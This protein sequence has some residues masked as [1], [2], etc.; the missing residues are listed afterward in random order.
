MCLHNYEES[1]L[2]FNKVI[3]SSLGTALSGNVDPSVVFG[4]TDNLEK[5]GNHII[6]ELMT[7]HFGAH[8]ILGFQIKP[9]IVPLAI[10]SDAKFTFGGKLD[11]SAEIG[12]TTFAVH[13][14]LALAF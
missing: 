9:P 6:S 7:P 1:Y 14:G 10:Y 8:L 4:N 12:S 2:Y 13:A 5:I 3:E 11:E